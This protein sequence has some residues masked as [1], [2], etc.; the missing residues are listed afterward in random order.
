[1]SNKNGKKTY[2]LTQ[3]K[4]KSVN[5][6]QGSIQSAK[7]T[8]AQ[9][10]H[11]SGVSHINYAVR[12]THISNLTLTLVSIIPFE[13]RERE[14]NACFYYVINPFLF[15]FSLKSK[16]YLCCRVVMHIQFHPTHFSFISSQYSNPALLT[17]P[18]LELDIT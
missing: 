7:T 5:R 17:R 6:K 16:K 8:K 2:I 3:P 9:V 1:V 11:V 15:F 10:V 12:F 18:A 14:S 13:E 4:R